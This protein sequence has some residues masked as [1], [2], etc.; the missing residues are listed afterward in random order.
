MTTGVDKKTT[1]RQET[2]EQGNYEAKSADFYADIDAK[3]KSGLGVVCV[4]NLP[5]DTSRVV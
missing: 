4:C 3:D 2:K 1:T 5:A